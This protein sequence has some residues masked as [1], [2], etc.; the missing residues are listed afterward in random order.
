MY[1][2]RK[3]KDYKKE[4]LEFKEI[5]EDKEER[6]KYIKK[7][8]NW[9][10]RDEISLNKEINNI[11]NNRK[12]KKIIK[13]VFYIV[14]E[15]IGRPR[16]GRNK[17]YIPNIQKFYDCMNDYLKVH[18]ELST[19]K[20]FTECKLDLKY[21]LKIP[22]DMTKIQ[23]MLAELKY[24]RHIKKPDWD[25][26]GKGSDMLHLL[27]LDDCLV[28][29]GRVRKFYSFKPRIEVRIVY[30]NCHQNSYHKKSIEKLFKDKIR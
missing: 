14:P 22:S 8:L 25:N 19:L 20:I 1:K 11:K 15:G 5:P 3:Q 17:F 24:I 4:Y 29:D 23:K 13:L 21:Y 10:D 28:S 7:L 18:K 12:N 6:I 9:K 2:K 27:W 16:K 26:L 30:Y